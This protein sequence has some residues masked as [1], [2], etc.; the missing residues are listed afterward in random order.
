VIGIVQCG[1]QFRAALQVVHQRE[2]RG[3]GAH[4]ALHQLEQALLAHLRR[5]AQQVVPQEVRKALL[6]HDL[7]QA[8]PAPL[9]RRQV[10]R[11]LHAGEQKFFS[12][13]VDDSSSPRA[14]SVSNTT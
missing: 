4:P 12:R 1:E 7:H 5:V 3:R 10:G 8:L 9:Q 2:H 6:P 11:R 13:S 14:F